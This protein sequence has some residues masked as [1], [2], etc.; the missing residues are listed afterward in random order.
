L[1]NAM[2]SSTTNV[3][4]CSNL[5]PYSWNNN[6]YT[7][8]GTYLVH[9]TNAA[10]CDSAATLNLLVNAMSSSTTNVTICSNLLPYS[11]NNNSYTGAGTY[12]VHLTNA[13]GCDSAATLNLSVNA[14]TS[15]TTNITI[16]SNL[17]PYSWN[18]N[19]YTG[20]GTYLVHLT[21][22]AGCD[23]AA[24]LNLLV[25]ATTSSTTNVTICS[26]LL[27]Y[28]WNNNSYTGAGTYLVHL[29]NAAGCDS[30]ATL[31]LLV[32]ATTSSTTNIT[33][34]SNLLPYSWN[35]NSYT[36]AGTYLVHLTNAAGCDSAATLNLLVNAT[37]SSTTNVTICSNLLPY[38][39]NNNSYTGAGTYLVHLTNA[40]GCDS[41]ATLNLLVNATTSSITNI[42]I[43]SNQLP[44]SWNN[45]SYTGAGTYLV[46]LT[47][48]AGCDSAA[49]LNLLVN[50]TTSST[51]NITICSNLLPYSWNNNS[52]TGAGTYLVHLTNAAGCDSAATLNLLVN[53]TSSSTTNITICSSLLP[54]SWNNNSFTGAGTY[55][56]HL[57]NAAGCDSA[58]T[59]NLSVNG[60]SSSTT[61]VTICVTQ[62]P[63]TWNGVDYTASGTY[64][65]T[66]TNI[67]GCDSIATLE[68]VITP[69][70]T[71]GTVSS[72]AT[73]CAGSNS[74]T[75]ILSD[76]TG[77]V[78]KWEQSTDGG[79]NWVTISNT[80]ASLSYVNLSQTTQYRAVVQSGTCSSANSSTA[81][82]AVNPSPILT[83]NL[84]EIA[85]SGAPF[86]YTPTS[87]AETT[88]AWTRAAVAGIS[89]LAASG[90]GGINETLIDT[91]GSPADVTYVYTLT[92]NNGCANIQNVVVTVN[93]P[94]RT[95]LIVI[96]SPQMQKPPVGQAGLE[97]KA[98][99]NPTTSYFNLVVKSNNESSISV[100]VVDIFG[101]V[102]EKHE[103]VIP[104]VALR[105]GRA[106]AGGIYFV[107][108]IQGNQRKVIRII[109]AN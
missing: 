44:Y 53:A 55:L 71:G 7:G 106:W 92:G 54:Y 61:N 16:C 35:N 52:Y 67:L 5:L 24:T 73:V 72:S 99:P 12:L 8:A 75:L 3:T 101:L 15:S 105:L 65:Y 91:T 84:T 49:T 83:S 19:S 41:A 57:T 21:N 28:S 82:I 27:P 6:S 46:H 88:F 39:W 22:A 103:K 107:E 68:L 31:N 80:S 56:V 26:N 38:S 32:N 2:S 81:T 59:L 96:G 34:C 29:T 45:N 93:L 9:L 47:N 86:S 100:R 64:T 77:V 94:L 58:A 1:V 30:A 97:I 23:S 90:S 48:A 25:N 33:I 69:P 89:N 36:G 98:A 17:L 40:A 78:I 4:I 95:A 76:N 37:S 109:K 50:A 20:A 11:W 74:G 104:G 108:V 63:Y 62:T 85:I 51:T 10:G 42:T 13:A 14:T 87:S 43:C 18:N 102:V 66:T 70:S 79:A 60:T